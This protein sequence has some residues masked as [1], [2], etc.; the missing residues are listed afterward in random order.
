M[1]PG[2]LRDSL[3][4][5]D[6]GYFEGAADVL[7]FVMAL[8]GFQATPAEEVPAEGF[9]PRAK[10]TP[11]TPPAESAAAIEERRQRGIRGVHIYCNTHKIDTKG[12][13][14]PIAEFSLEEFPEVF[15][16]PAVDVSSKA[17]DLPQ[18]QRFSLSLQAFVREV[19]QNEE[20]AN[21]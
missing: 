6:P 7:A 1:N 19:R 10:A 3:D 20:A 21:G 12:D 4:G 5:A 18:L 9:A 13:A 2:R 16:D 11:A 8:A 15:S 14:S 17:L